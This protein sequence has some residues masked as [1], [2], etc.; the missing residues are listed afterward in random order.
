V[1]QLTYTVL[2]QE[3][4]RTVRDVLTAQLHVSSSLRKTLVQRKGALLLNGKAV[5][6]SA[7]LSAGDVLTVDVSDPETLSPI[8]PVDFPLAVLWEDEHLLAV[9]K[10]AGIT[11]HG[12][13]LTEESV[14]IAGAA[15]HYLGSTAVHVVNRLDRGTSGVMLIAKS[16]YMH[17]RCME[18]LHT[19][20]FC[21]GYV[22][23]CEGVPEPAHG[24][25]DVPIGRDETSLLRRC[26]RADGQPAVTEYE[27]QET[28]NGRSLVQLLP[29]T[30]RTHQLRVHM[31]HIGHPLVGDWLYGTEDKTLIT[32]P[33]LHS[34]QL[35]FTHPLTGEVVALTA[36][37][38]KDMARLL[39]KT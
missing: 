19:E 20:A 1:P 3:Q 28:Q 29:Q 24:I 21:R 11:V 2:P 15:A 22:A 33:P 4:G 38:P 17:A 14:T 34:Y 32:R 7:R 6:L 10:P 26:V 12:A 30:G 5:F 27:V 35:R 18:L 31:A 16:G 25:I 39:E 36:P 8:V 9:D 23:I 37:L 13:A